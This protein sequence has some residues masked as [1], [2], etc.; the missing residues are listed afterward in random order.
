MND[1]HSPGRSPSPKTAPLFSISGYALEEIKV[2][3]ESLDGRHLVVTCTLNTSDKIIRTFALID[4]GATG[5]AFCD[6]DFLNSHQLPTFELK[7]PRQLEVIDGRPISSGDITHLTK[8]GLSINDHHEEIPMFVTK[9]G[10]Y[11]LVLG[12]PWL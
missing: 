3:E 10:S 12:I 8:I 4:C 1:E 2:M 5:F 6:K 9:L 7:Q 11:P